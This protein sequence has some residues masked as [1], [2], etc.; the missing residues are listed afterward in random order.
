M[1][2]IA[3]RIG[4]LQHLRVHRVL[5][6]GFALAS[7]SFPTGCDPGNADVQGKVVAERGDDVSSA[8]SGL[9]NLNDERV[10]PF[11]QTDAKATV[12]LFTRIDCPISNRYAPQVRRLYAEFASRGVDFW[13]V[14]AEPDE[15]AEV[16][17]KHLDEYDYPCSALRD[18]EH[19]LVRKTEAHVT[20]EAA[21][22]VPGGEM[23][24]CGRIDNWYVDF[25][26]ARAQAT[27]HDLHESLEATLSG[28]PVPT[29]RTLAVGCYISE[30]K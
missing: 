3:N 9:L 29:A 16:I 25:G 22:F 15:S 18:P 20:P 30:L 24:Y 1:T 17:R 2:V 19:W 6:L 21:V 13:L 28:R 14:Y 12:F 5:C 10:D 11:E 23:V 4:C 8:R 27:K 7:V 26:K